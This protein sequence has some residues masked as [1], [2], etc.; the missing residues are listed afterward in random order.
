MH[1]LHRCRIAKWLWGP[2]PGRPIL[3][4]QFDA[5][6]VSEEKHLYRFVRRRTF[7]RDG[8]NQYDATRPFARSVPALG[9]IPVRRTSRALKRERFEEYPLR[10]DKRQPGR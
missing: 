1:S 7:R 9:Y 6:L 5:S 10:H 8:R 3:L 4:V 2:D